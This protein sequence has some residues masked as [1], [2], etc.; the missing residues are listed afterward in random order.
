MLDALEGSVHAAMAGER[1]LDQESS[2]MAPDASQEVRCSLCDLPLRTRYKRVNDPVTGEDFAIGECPS[3]GLGVTLPRVDDLARYYGP[4]YWG[5]RHAFTAD[6]C[7][8][9]R[10]RL[11]SSQMHPKPGH[12]LLDFGCGDGHFLQRA[13]AEGWSCIGYESSF[14]PVRSGQNYEIV[15]TLEALAAKAPFDAITLW[16]V[17]EHL[18]DPRE[19]LR[20]LSGMLTP[21]GLMIVAVPDAGGV[22]AKLFG[23]RWMH[24]DVPRHLYHFGAES[25]ERVLK[26]ADL[27]PVRRWQHEFEY[28]V[29]GWAQSAL[30][31]AGMPSAFFN[32][33]TGRMSFGPRWVGSFVAGSAI[34]AATLPFAL[35][36]GSSVTVAARRGDLS[37]R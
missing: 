20:E 12:R 4:V 3:C 27:A 16:H 33:V 1:Q 7:A 22:Q 23:P 13:A 25:L 34:S 18:P 30:A 35:K 31:A 24:L 11:L 2:R 32:A 10:V 28:D 36:W 15:P 29:M 19:T 14:S 17:L 9:R 5:G 26:L 21:N 6:F 8:R 37:T